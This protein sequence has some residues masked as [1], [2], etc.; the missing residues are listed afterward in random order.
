MMVSY[1]ASMLETASELA[2]AGFL[3]NTV[4]VP[5]ANEALKNLRRFTGV[6]VLVGIGVGIEL[7]VW[8]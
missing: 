8:I 6:G 4:E 2:S 1:G 7:A 5:S 3:L